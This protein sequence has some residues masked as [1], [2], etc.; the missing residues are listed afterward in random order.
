MVGLFIYACCRP[1]FVFEIYLPS[2][3]V[4]LF[5]AETSQIQ[6]KWTETIAKRFVPFVA[7]NLTEADY[8]LIGQLFYKDCHAL[9][10]WRK[11]WFAMDKSSLCF[12][13]QTQEAQEERMNLRRLQELSKDPAPMR[14]GI[15]LLTACGIAS[16]T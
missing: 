13:L 14:V 2:E 9:D 7:E 15:Y 10:Q 8:D 12:C 1:I 3:R 11:G 16:F 6:R 4:F 5:G